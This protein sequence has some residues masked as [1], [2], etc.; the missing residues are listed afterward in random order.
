MNMTKQDFTMIAAAMILAGA[1]TPSLGQAPVIASFGHNGELVCTNLEPGSAATVEWAPSVTGPWTSTWVGLEAVAV[2]SNR[3]IRVSVPMFYRVRSV[4]AP[5]VTPSVA[6]IPAGNFTMGD[7]FN[8]GDNNELPTHTVQVSAFYMDRHEVSKALWDEVYHWATNHGYGFEY[9]A[10]GKAANYP[11]H[12]LTWYDAVKWCNARSEK[13]GRT[14]AYYTDAGLTQR[15]RSG[16]VAPFVNWSAGYRL[17]TEA[18]WEKAARGGATGRRFPWVDSDTITHSR[19]NYNSDASYA[20]DT[21]STRGYHPT[22]FENLLPPQVVFTSPVGYFAPNGY[23][24]YDM[25][26]NVW[27][28]CWDWYGP[29]SSA[30]QNDPRGPTTGSV[31]VLRGGAYE[32]FAFGCRVARRFDGGD[33]T[34]GNGG[35]GFRS[36]LPPGQP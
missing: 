6:L 26:G 5:A 25:A 4:D 18:E 32:H 24:L 28:Y 12:S 3:T 14:P 31:R 1:G 16:Q 7:T 21:S 30:S 34:W 9:R 27:E 15:Y 19:A 36:V 2:D 8:E 35:I 22:F 23:G 11:A 13:E 33:P 10:Q 20:Y 29:Y 17:P